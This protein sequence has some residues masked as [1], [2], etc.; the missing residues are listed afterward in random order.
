MSLKQRPP[1][2]PVPGPPAHGLTLAMLK[3]SWPG[4]SAELV[5]KTIS[6]VDCV[7]ATEGWFVESLARNGALTPPIETSVPPASMPLPSSARVPARPVTEPVDTQLAPSNRV[8][9]LGPEAT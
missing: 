4:I 6:L 9:K 8:T 1:Y 5:R 7:I 3:Y 2:G